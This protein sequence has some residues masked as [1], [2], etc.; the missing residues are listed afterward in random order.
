MGYRHVDWARIRRA[1][2]G[3]TLA[4]VRE[5]AARFGVSAWSIYRRAKM[6]GWRRGP[7]PPAPTED[8]TDLP[9][10][11]PGDVIDPAEPHQRLWRAVVMTGILEA[12]APG[13]MARRIGRDP[14]IRH[15]GIVRALAVQYLMSPAFEEHLALAG[16]PIDPDWVRERVGRA[17]RELH[18]RQEETR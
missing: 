4:P 10:V 8:E 9:I 1:F 13:K 3:E 12:L 2:E 5:L 17:L 11:F 15:P 16:L 14:W 18:R 6:E 7:R